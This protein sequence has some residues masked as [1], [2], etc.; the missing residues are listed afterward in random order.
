M[1]G[2]EGSDVVREVGDSVERFATGDRVFAFGGR[3]GFYA[4]LTAR[5]SPG[6]SRC[7]HRLRV[8]Q[9]RL[10]QRR[11]TSRLDSIPRAACERS[12][13]NGRKPPLRL[14]GLCEYLH[15]CGILLVVAYTITGGA[16][17]Q[18]GDFT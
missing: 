11:C 2:F 10:R 12:P 4:E 3:P 8:G 6:G 7:R 5:A 14:S 15:L 18:R 9:R 13:S 17:E 16:S 1:P